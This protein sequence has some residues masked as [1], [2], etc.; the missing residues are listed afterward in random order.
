MV[1]FWFWFSGSFLTGENGGVKA[2]VV[3]FVEEF[4]GWLFGVGE[5][6]DVV[7]LLFEVVGKG[8]HVFVFVVGMGKGV[9]PERGGGG[10]WYVEVG[11]DGVPELLFGDGS[12]LEGWH[13]WLVGGGEGLWCDGEIL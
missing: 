10:L 3:L 1:D 7:F 8:E 13:K 6:S 5:K 9:F 2:G 11:A 4:H 12:F